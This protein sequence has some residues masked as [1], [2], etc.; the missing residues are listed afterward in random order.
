MTTT[1][2]AGLGASRKSRT[3]PAK[4][5]FCLVTGVSVYRLFQEPNIFSSSSSSSPDNCMTLA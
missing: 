3:R 2:P 1:R 5:I 4:T